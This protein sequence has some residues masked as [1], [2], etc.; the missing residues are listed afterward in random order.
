MAAFES[1]VRRFTRYVASVA[2][3]VLGD[4]HEASDV[5]QESFIKAYRKLSE[6]QDPRSFK[7]WL[8]TLTR[9]TAL[10]ARR[11]RRSELSLD[12]GMDDSNDEGESES[13]LEPLSREASP[14]ALSLDR[15]LR[16][17]IRSRVAQLPESQRE[18]VI[19]K[20]LDGLSYEEIAER[21]NSTAASVESRLHRARE[22]LRGL[23]KDL[24]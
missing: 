20:Y 1:L 4:E 18:V 23:F 13:K 12:P 6:L 8:R 2:L 14:E 10:D 21:T 24:A 15:E 11:R 7:A 16:A 19:L 17:E 22:R 9:S 5:A 3:A